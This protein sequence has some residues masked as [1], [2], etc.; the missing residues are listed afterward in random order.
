MTAYNRMKIAL[1]F[2]AGLLG[3][4]LVITITLWPSAEKPIQ[5]QLDSQDA[6][7]RVHNINQQAPAIRND[8]DEKQLF[9]FVKPGLMNCDDLFHGI[10]LASL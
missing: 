7:V 8:I 5:V 10:L 6:T 1:W 3:A 4:T 9:S 2:F